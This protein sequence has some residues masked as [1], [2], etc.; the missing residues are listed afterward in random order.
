MARVSRPVICI[1]APLVSA[2]RKRVKLFLA[3]LGLSVMPDG[4]NKEQPDPLCS[5]F[6]GRVG[7]AP[8]W[9]GSPDP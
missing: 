9:H 1:A 4:G 5:T 7:R 2:A 6:F 8:T 3:T